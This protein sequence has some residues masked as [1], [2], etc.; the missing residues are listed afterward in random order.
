MFLV[1]V[2]SKSTIPFSEDD[3]IDT[4]NSPYACTKLSMEIFAKTYNQ[5]YGLKS[6]G[7]RFFTVYGPRGRPD[8]A[9]YKFMRAIKEGREFEKY[10]DGTTSRDYTYIDD[11]VDGVVSVIDNPAST[12][13]NWSPKTPSASSSSAPYKL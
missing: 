4:C 11:I 12:D 6:I 2:L 9:P 8:M 7:L 3:K 5:M 1:T 10:G 13:I